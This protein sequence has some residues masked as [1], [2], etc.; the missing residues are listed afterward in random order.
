MVTG[1]RDAAGS[2][3]GGRVGVG[4]GVGGRAGVG[5]GMDVGG[6][7]VVGSGTELGDRAGVGA[8]TDVGGRAE[9]GAGTDVGAGTGP[10]RDGYPR[11]RDTGRSDAGGWSG[12]GS[13]RQA[14]DA[15]GPAPPDLRLVPGAVAAW[16]TMILG[17]ALGPVAAGLVAGASGLT[18]FGTHRWRGPAWLLAAAACAGAAGLVATASTLVVAGHPLHAAA[19]RG[20]AA[21]LR[22]VVEDDPRLLRTVGQGGGP[23]QVVVEAWLLDVEVGGG[24]WRSGGRVL[25][26]APAAGWAG[27]L[28][29]TT[30]TAEGLLAPPDRND[31]TV[32]V[33]RVRGSPRDLVGPPWWQTAADGLRTGLRDASAAT[34]GPAEAGLLPGLAVGDTS[35]LARETEEDFRAAGLTHL[36]AVSGANLA[37]LAGAVLG[38]LRLLRAGPRVSAAM[39]AAA[40]VGF[41]VLARP[42]PSVLRAAVM[43]AIALWALAAGRGRSTLPALAAAVLVLLVVQPPLAL[44]AGFALSVLATAALVL[45]APAWAQAL[46]RRGVPG[47][48]AEA[49]AVPAAAFLLTAPVIAGIGGQLSAVSVVA[50][51]LAAPAVA[52]ATVL[53]VGS[54]LVSPVAPGIAR[55]CTLA[56][57][58]FVG[59]LVTVA[60]RSAAVPGAVVAWP[61][62]VV[63]GL[64]LAAALAGLV[65]LGRSRRWRAVLVAAVLGAALVLVPTRVLPPGWPPTGWRV[66]ACDVGQ[67][68]AVVLATAEPGWVVLVDTG[69]DPGP[70]DG[71][72]SRLGVRGIALVV[73][74]HLHADHVG[75]LAGALR[76]RPVGGVAVGPE[77]EPAPAL[78]D[79]A[80]LA[81]AA[82][83]PLVA[84]AA[85]RRLAWPG[86]VV[87][88]LGPPHPAAH[89]DPNDGT[90]VNDGSL[91]LRAATPAGTVLLPGD[92]EL[93]EQADLL[94][95]HTDLHADVLKMPHHGS[96]YSD[97]AFLA[98]VGAR[99]VLVSVGAGNPYG[100]PSVP[101]LA[102][103]SGGGAT[104]RRTDQSGDVA[105]TGAGDHLEVVARGSPRPAPRRRV[106]GPRPRGPRAPPGSCWARSRSARPAP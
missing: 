65:L 40:L 78:H 24:R 89:V 82:R 97:P 38:L 74:S 53:G 66:V 63:G 61:S 28:P 52:P 54:A 50:N 69:P 68:D 25:L 67:G 5:A 14:P 17:L 29:G 11:V 9:P 59:W 20:E 101:L 85:G 56:A 21:R 31:L 3:P 27:L 83:V 41:V 30:C 75:G 48:A 43:G 73:L 6:R 35:R 39:A 18:A 37:V 16:A 77:R 96:R 46:R 72:L 87:D 71:C 33:L 88:V 103:L 2:S 44:D 94:G 93:A 80:R 55:A 19:Q 22:V 47:W 100:H 23:A 34:L 8:G 92:A 81:A 60:G 76:G 4:T 86:L 102:A 70:V 64:L 98:A 84:L 32:A 1:R 104:V 51:L 106:R 42:S 58:P 95:L 105:V 90:Q 13:R 45:C 57:G 79:V 49:L 62:G 36:V 15:D 91:V 99:A 7:A 12:A 10:G 26:L